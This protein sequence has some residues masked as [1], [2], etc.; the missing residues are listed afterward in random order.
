VRPEERVMFEIYRETS[1]NMKYRVVYFTELGDHDKDK[2]ISHALAGDHVFDGFLGSERRRE[3][4]RAIAGLLER[5][6]D[7]DALSG[8]QIEVELEPFLA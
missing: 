7:G 1:Y 5:M 3:A 4:K 2:E 8:Q 6:N